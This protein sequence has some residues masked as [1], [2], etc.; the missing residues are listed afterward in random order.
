MSRFQGRIDF[1]DVKYIN[2]GH[3]DADL[4]S[5]AQLA[6]LSGGAGREVNASSIYGIA[7]TEE[8]RFMNEW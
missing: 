2:E 1:G 7:S 6:V 4:S 3:G 5:E 8:D